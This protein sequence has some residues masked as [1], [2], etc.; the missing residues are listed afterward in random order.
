VSDKTARRVKCGQNHV[1][2]DQLVRLPGYSA[3]C[4]CGKLTFI[5]LVDLGIYWVLDKPHRV[6]PD[7]PVDAEEACT[8]GHPESWHRWDAA[9]CYPRDGHGCPCNVYRTHPDAEEGKS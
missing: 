8:C 1:L 5:T 2:G 6:I 3:P 7:P 9:E 4:E